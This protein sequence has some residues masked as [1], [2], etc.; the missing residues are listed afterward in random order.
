MAMCIVNQADGH[1]LFYAIFLRLA[2]LFLLLLDTL[3]TLIVVVLERCA[4]LGLHALC[5]LQ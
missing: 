1:T 2:M 5:N 3:D 4:L